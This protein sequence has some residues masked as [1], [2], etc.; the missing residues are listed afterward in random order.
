MAERIAEVARR[1]CEA[2]RPSPVKVLHS[3]CDRPTPFGADP[4]PRLLELGELKFFG[5]GRYGLGSL[6]LRLLEFFERGVKR[7]ADAHA[8]SDRRFPNLIGA[9][10]LEKCRYFRSFPHSLALVSH[11]REDLEA[12]Q[13]FAEDVR[14]DG[15]HLAVPERTL[16]PAKCVLAPTIC[17]HHYAWLE[18]TADCPDQTV[19][20]L[21]KCFRYESGNLT[22]LER[23][24]DF[25]MREIIWVGT[26][27]YVLGRQRTVHR[28][29]AE[30]VGRVGPQL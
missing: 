5:A 6:P 7:L 10:T 8:A 22:G 1:L 17:F 12:I 23:L 24:W 13:R 20:A 26:A 14:W 2:H 16:A 4:H 18:N 21:G 15:D 27:E 11:L 29:I 3:R 19:T 28:G 30:N 9:E 25:S